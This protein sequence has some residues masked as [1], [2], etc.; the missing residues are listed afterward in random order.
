MEPELQR[1]AEEVQ[2]AASK[3][4]KDSPQDPGDTEPA[5]A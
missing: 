5:A 1:T 2:P 3:S 4:T